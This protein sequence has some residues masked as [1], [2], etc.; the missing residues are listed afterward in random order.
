MILSLCVAMDNNGVIGKKGKL[1]W[2][3]PA[4]LKRFKEL[5][6]GKAVVMGRNTFFSIGKPLS[7]R[8]NVVLTSS[9]SFSASS[10]NVAHSIEEATNIAFSLGI[11]ELVFIGGRKIYEAAIP[12]V[13]K[14]YITKVVHSFAGDV[15]FPADEVDWDDWQLNWADTVCPGN[16]T[17]YLLIFEIYERRRYE[18]IS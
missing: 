12:I 3:I 9:P 8:L 18:T 10:V 2:R 1:P 13:Q 11:E 14:M 6:V 4:D 15:F 17:D 5:T 7:D 16:K